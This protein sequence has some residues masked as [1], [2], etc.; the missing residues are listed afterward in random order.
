VLATGANI[1]GYMDRACISVVAPRIRSDL[2]FSATE[3]G[4]IFG[5]FSLSYA[6]FQVPWGI[7]ADRHGVR[8]IV[9]GVILLWSAFTTLTAVAWSFGSMALFRFLFGVSEAS[10]SPAVASEF[11]HSVPPGRRSTAFGLFLAGGRV[12]GI[13]APVRT[14]FVAVRYGWRAVFFLFASIGFAALA[15]WLGAFPRSSSEPP[16]GRPN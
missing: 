11:R 2:G 4:P 6:L 12:G 8:T 10:L 1:L 3:M 5:A 16:G 7:I 9:A 15:M 13:A 14:A